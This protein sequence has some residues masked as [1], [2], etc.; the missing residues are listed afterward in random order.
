VLGAHRARIGR[1][2][3]SLKSAARTF[4]YLRLAALA[5]HLERTADALGEAEYCDL[6]A[7]MDAAFAAARAQD[8]QSAMRSG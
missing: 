4:G 6:L 1:E 7:R 8:C 3:H 5:L 2:A